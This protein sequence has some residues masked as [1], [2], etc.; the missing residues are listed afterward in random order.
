MFNETGAIPME[1]CVNLQKK[2]EASY[3]LNARLCGAEADV[4]EL[5][6]EIRARGW[7]IA[8]MQNTVL[9]G[10]VATRAS[11][12]FNTT[13]ESGIEDFKA[14]M[15]AKGYFIGLTITKL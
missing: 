1:N 14:A 3:V 6:S 9:L 10:S 12:N 8:E 15:N 7:K 5:A 2:T 13:D 11:I 4:A